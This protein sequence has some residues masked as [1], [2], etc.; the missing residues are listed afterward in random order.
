MTTHICV[1]I[2]VTKEFYRICTLSNV[3]HYYLYFIVFCIIELSQLGARSTVFKNIL[4]L[5]ALRKRFHTV[6]WCTYMCVHLYNWK[7]SFTE[8][9]WLSLHI[10]RLL[11]S[12]SIVL[13]FCSWLLSNIWL[14]LH[15]QASCRADSMRVWRTPAKE[16]APQGGRIITNILALTMHFTAPW[17][18][19]NLYIVWMT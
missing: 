5:S 1:N 3:I 18:Q 2:Y 16:N 11:I 8:R 14:Y 17:S 12:Y 10:K 6:I 9:Y 7:K 13:L 15:L 19:S 4:L